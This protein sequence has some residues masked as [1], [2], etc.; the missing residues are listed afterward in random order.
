MA[1]SGI[2]GVVFDLDGTLVDS[3]GTT[4]DGFNYGITLCGGRSHT[5][6]EIMAHFGTGEREIFAK[7][8]GRDQAARAY[9]AFKGY[10]Q[11]SLESVPLHEG[12]PQLLNEL[13]SRRIPLSIVTGR[14]WNTT[15]VILKHHGILDRFVTV[16]A[17]DHVP[18]PKPQ[19]DGIFLAL[20][21]MALRPQESIYVGDSVVDIQAS[22]SAG[23]K[24]VAA[25]WDQLVCAED[26]AAQK[27]THSIQHPKEILDILS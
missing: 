11:E 2:K 4:L 16:V 10:L 20:Q 23:S 13:K 21:R 8:V 7:I 3:L 25:L 17:H 24:S 5:P 22:H 14:S 6:Q 19:P 9:E 15:E 12:V 26:L 27:P 1:A 18:A